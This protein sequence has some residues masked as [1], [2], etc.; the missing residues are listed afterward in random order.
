MK[1][2]HQNEFEC[3]CKCGRVDMD[4]KFLELLD[5]LRDVYRKPLIV[6]SGY[7]CSSHNQKVSTTGP[8]GPH[9]TGKA[10]DFA[11]SGADAYLLVKIA[12]QMGD[13]TGIG[14]N[15]KGAARFVHL[16][17]L[18]VTGVHPRPGLWSY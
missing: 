15:Q 5:R 2:F 7:R 8:H 1:Y 17:T 12:M 6:S 14:I 10:V 18:P 11:V 3:R 13:F 4:P 9:T 16:D